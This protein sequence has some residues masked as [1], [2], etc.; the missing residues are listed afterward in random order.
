MCKLGPRATPG[1]GDVTKGM[2][3]GRPGWLCA[4][5]QVA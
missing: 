3:L 5:G 4:L 2:G 1:I